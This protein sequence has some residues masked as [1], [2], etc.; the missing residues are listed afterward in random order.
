MTG[1]ELR[2]MEVHE[3]K[4]EDPD[5]SVA[6]QQRAHIRNERT[7]EH[8]SSSGMEDGSGRRARGSRPEQGRAGRGSL[9]F[10]SGPVA[11]PAAWQGWRGK[12]PEGPGVG[13]PEGQR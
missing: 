3:S 10:R 1:L 7:K 2:T 11:Q 13:G 8:G 9:P 5:G 6:Q 4:I 12:S